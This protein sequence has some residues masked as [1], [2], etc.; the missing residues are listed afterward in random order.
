MLK[1]LLTPLASIAIAATAAFSFDMTPSVAQSYSASGNGR[2]S[3]LV[4]VLPCSQDRGS[5]GNYYDYGYW[6]G[7]SWC[8]VSGA[9][10]YWVYEYPN[11]YVWAQQGKGGGNF[12]SNVLLPASA[13]VEGSYY[14]LQQ[15]LTCHQDRSTYGNFSDYGYWGGGSWCG[16][17][18]QAGYWVYVYPNWYVWSGAR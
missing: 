6:G 18:G 3:D 7:G 10:G 4:Q 1:R 8:G 5:Y 15:I 2:Y 13:S 11:W 9:A 16:Q 17:S 12:A 14:N